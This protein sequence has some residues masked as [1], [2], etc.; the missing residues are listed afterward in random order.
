MTFMPGAATLSDA[1]RVELLAAVTASAAAMTA[2]MARR[3]RGIGSVSPA[4]GF[5]TIY[6]MFLHRSLH[7]QKYGFSQGFF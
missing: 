7:G 5:I 2:S 4:K 6:G 1:A 3:L